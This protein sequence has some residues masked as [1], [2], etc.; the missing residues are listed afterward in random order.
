MELTRKL[1]GAPI[2]ILSGYRN[3]K[4]NRLAGGVV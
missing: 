2:A 4:V 1:Y 3:E